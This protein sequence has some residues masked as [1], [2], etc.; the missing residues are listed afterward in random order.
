M[1][2]CSNFLRGLSR[3]W[4]V[5]FLLSPMFADA[6]SQ[7]YPIQIKVL[8]SEYRA[9]NTETPVPKDCDL[10]NFSAYCNESRNPSVQNI[11]V[12]Q[13]AEG[14]SFTISCTVDS[15]WSKCAPLPVGETFEARKEKRGITVLYRDAKGKEK[16]EFYQ[17][18]A[19]VSGAQADTV[20]APQPHAAAPVQHAPAATPASAPP[21]Q[22]NSPTKTEKVKCNF[23]STPSGAEI[24]LDGKY[25][26]NTPSEIA[27]SA[28]TH[29]VI[30]SMPGFTQWQ[31]D[32]T[33]M[34]GSELTVSA[35]LQKQPQ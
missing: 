8:S 11:M 6:A 24:T 27:V 20:A 31:R 30:F 32:L 7:A 19:A 14:K 22:E 1:G 29:V 10:Q 35:I 17:V 5:V 18:L 4:P 2:T 21:V 23:S 34:P 12:V 15:R 3:L 33:V 13:D 9:L 26:G 16:K 28:G 25:V